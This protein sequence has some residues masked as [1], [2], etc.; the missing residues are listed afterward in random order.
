MFFPIS[1]DHHDGKVGIVSV[2]IILLCIVVHLFVEIDSVRVKKDIEG[3]IV[4]WET[5]NET[6]SLIGVASDQVKE[7]RR[8]KSPATE[9]S[10]GQSTYDQMTSTFTA[11]ASDRQ[12]QLES[13]ID[14]VHQTSLLYR[15]ALVKDHLS[16]FDLFT[17]MFI[18]GGWIHLLGNLWFF[19]IAGVMME[20]YWGM[21]KYILFFLFF[22][23]F[24]GI[25]FIV[26]S[27]IQGAN[28]SSIPLVGASGAIAGMMG[29]LW[30]VGKK[31]K[32][33]I[34]YFFVVRWGVF[35]LSMGWFLGIYFVE[36]LVY[37]LLFGKT[38]GVAYMA[39]V[40]GFVL[41]A[42][43][44]HLIHGHPLIAEEPK[45]KQH[46]ATV[47]AAVIGSDI[48][49]FQRNPVDD[50]PAIPQTVRSA[51]KKPSQISEAWDLV[52]KK[53]FDGASE[54]FVRSIHV[55]FLD[56][57]RFSDKV[58]LEI[59]KL[60]PIAKNL[61][62][63]SETY[64]DWAMQSESNNLMKSAIICYE[65]SAQFTKDNM[66]F[67]M[68]T[69]LKSAELRVESGENVARAIK[70]LQIIIQSDK[71]GRYATAARECLAKI[72]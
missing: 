40:A 67:R 13:S 68:K 60:Y 38:T 21:G 28:V 58:Q 39:H 47:K 59:E 31:I 20:R 30:A 62:I 41:G 12:A 22:G 27:E 24:S 36:Q 37:G 66:E 19:Y 6:D 48:N 17:Y 69:L 57:I 46:K 71:S 70:F 63:P 1:T 26:L 8:S 29:A 2:V 54:I 61:K 64:Y 25:G 3:V 55:Y 42:V 51:V 16:F 35:E 72:G 32:V 43:F 5:F 56:L 15:G 7:M 11:G 53:D 65:L 50:L 10:S 18:H 52:A 23:V 44:G 9:D 33:K 49:S 34:A 4:A 14:S 45:P